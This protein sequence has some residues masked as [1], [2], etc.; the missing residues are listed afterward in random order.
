MK[1][2]PDGRVISCCGECSFWEDYIPKTM[3]GDEIPELCE[4]L[5]CHPDNMEEFVLYNMNRIHV[6]CSLPDAEVEE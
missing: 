6:D 2:L 5:C 3:L 1:R 4:T